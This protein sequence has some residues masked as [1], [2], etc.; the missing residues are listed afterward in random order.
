MKGRDTIEVVFWNPRLWWKG[1][2]SRSL[3]EESLPVVRQAAKRTAQ[4][5]WER[6]GRNAGMNVVRIRFDRMYSEPVNGVRVMKP[7]Q[8]VTGQFTRQQLERGQLDPVQLTIIQ[9]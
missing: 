1:E 4:E 5:V 2:F 3:P 9:K 7:A 6:Y 8:V